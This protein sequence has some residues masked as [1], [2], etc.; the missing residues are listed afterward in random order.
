MLRYSLI[1]AAFVVGCGQGPAPSS[2]NS[3]PAGEKFAGAQPL[4]SQAP[5]QDFDAFEPRG[6]ARQADAVFTGTVVSVKGAF[7]GMTIWS[8]V[9]VRPDRVLKGRPE[10][11]VVVPLEGGSAT[12]GTETVQLIV[13]DGMDLPA[14]GHAALFFLGPP[15]VEGKRKPVGSAHAVAEVDSAGNAHGVAVSEVARQLREEQG[16]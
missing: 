11:S 4:T 14:V 2:S 12:I 8:D 1:L 6:L 7:D 5:G 13:E 16:Q 15:G 10:A 3:V 9:T